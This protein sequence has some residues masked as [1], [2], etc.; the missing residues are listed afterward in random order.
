MLAGHSFCDGA[1]TLPIGE[2]TT[3]TKPE[4]KKSGSEHACRGTHG[5]RGLVG[6]PLAEQ[7]RHLGPLERPVAAG[8]GVPA[9]SPRRLGAPPTPLGAYSQQ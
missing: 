8:P 9:V 3:A 4:P 1:Q 2:D 6:R 7:S 5:A